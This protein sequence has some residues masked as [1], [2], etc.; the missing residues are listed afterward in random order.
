M[1]TPVTGRRGFTLIELLVTIAIIS[2]LISLLLPAVQQAREAARKTQCKSSI[3][4]ITLAL[5]NYH[6]TFKIFPSGQYFCQSGTDCSSSAYY[7]PGWGWSVSILPYVEQ[8]AIYNR[9]NFSLSMADPYHAPVLATPIVLFHCPSDATRNDSVPPSGFIGWA[10]R[11]A[12]SNYVGNGGSFGFSF[13]VP[14]IEKNEQITNGV[15]GRDSARRFHEISD[16]L[17]NTFLIGESIHYNFYWDPTL[18]GNYTP[19][20]QKAC[21]TLTLVRQG[22]WSMNPGFGASMTAQR[23]SF[24]SLHEGGAHFG[25]CDGSVR[26]V[27][28]NIDHTARHP[29]AGTGVDPFDLANGGIGYGVWQRLFSRNDSLVTGEF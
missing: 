25:L 15:M 28:E 18:Y 20:V 3:R 13:N 21:C 7:A 17:S 2:V 23:E 1:R 16:G 26:F 22:N 8:A 11:I 12:T 27:S 9:I 29:Y 6:E 10:E 4:Q 5:H 14:W 24:A 19:G